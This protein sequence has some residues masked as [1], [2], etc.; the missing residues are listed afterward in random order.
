MG[1]VIKAEKEIVRVLIRTNRRSADI[2]MT[3]QKVSAHLKADT[4]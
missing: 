2:S 4:Q 1:H 3:N